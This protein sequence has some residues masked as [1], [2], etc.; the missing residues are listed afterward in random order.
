MSNGERQKRRSSVALKMLLLYFEAFRFVR[1]LFPDEGDLRRGKLKNTVIT[2]STQLTLFF[3]LSLTQMY[4]YYAIFFRPRR[5]LNQTIES[6]LM[7]L[8]GRE[9]NDGRSIDG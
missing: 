3:C 5:T 7:M 1:V 6:L 9:P 4:I 8:S 2:A